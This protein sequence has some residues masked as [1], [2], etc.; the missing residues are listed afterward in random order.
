MFDAKRAYPLVLI[1]LIFSLITE[2]AF[3]VWA[4]IVLIAVLIVRPTVLKPLVSVFESVTRFIGTWASNVVLGAIFFLIVV[5]Y[6]FL[7]RKVEKKLVRH[8]FDST[9]GTFFTEDTKRY[10]PKHFEKPW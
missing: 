6:G 4:A 9:G 1:S 5:P 2:A 8:F 3:F 10:E 7:Y